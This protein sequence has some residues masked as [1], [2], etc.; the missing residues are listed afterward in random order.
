MILNDWVR[1]RIPYF[2]PPP[3]EPIFFQTDPTGKEGDSKNKNSEKKIEAPQQKISSIRVREEFKGTEKSH[4]TEDDDIVSS[5]SEE[6]EQDEEDV[7]WEDV[8]EST[9]EEAKE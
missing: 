6:A 2:V 8:V 3:E 5:G 1:G 9:K 4:N 7:D